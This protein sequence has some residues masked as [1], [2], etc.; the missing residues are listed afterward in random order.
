MDVKYARKDVVII[1]G[2]PGGVTAAKEAGKLGA[3]VALIEQDKPGGRALWHSLVPSKVWLDAADTGDEVVHAQEM[4]Y[5]MGGYIIQ[6]EKVLERLQTVKDREHTRD[7]KTFEDLNVEVFNGKGHFLDDYTIQVTRDGEEVARVHGEQIIIASGSVPIFPDDLK[8]D[9]KR[10]LAPRFMSHR[11]SIPESII[12]VGGGVTGSETIYLFNRLGS[13]V[14]ALTDIDTLLPRSDA[15][16]SNTLESVLS[17]RGVE[18]HKGQA[19][20]SI[21]NHGDHVEATLT[22][23]NSFEAELAFVAIGRVPDTSRLNLGKTGVTYDKHKGITVDGQLRTK[24]QHIFAI[25][26]VTGPPMLA[27]KAIAQARFAVS[28][29]LKKTNYSYQPDWAVE[30]IYTVP[31]VAQI[32][33]TETEAF[34]KNRNVRVLKTDYGKVLKSNIIEHQEGFLKMLV[35]QDNDRIL[36]ASAVGDHAADLL[37]PVAVALKAEMTFHSFQQIAPAN[38]TISEL[39]VALE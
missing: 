16:I 29:A 4:S 3:S 25:G 10:I 35:N 5:P 19:V 20:Q 2:G 21:V 18:F 34:K 1:G 26:D 30:A 13:E 17:R 38:P 14:T 7:K 12:V 23:G 37:A 28:N 27:N 33:M 32:G 31:E 24:V 9:G 6:P 36:G 39:L 22:S 11:K 8:P 15:D